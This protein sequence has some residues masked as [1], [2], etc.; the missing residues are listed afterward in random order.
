MPTSVAATVP[1]PVAVRRRRS[2][3]ARTGP[4][5]CA[6][7]SAGSSTAARDGGRTSCSAALGR[8]SPASPSAPRGGRGA[9]WVRHGAAAAPRPGGRGLLPGRA[10]T[11]GWDAGRSRRRAG[12][13]VVDAAG[14]GRLLRRPTSTHA[15]RGRGHPHRRA[16][17]ASPRADR[18]LDGP[19]AQRP[20]PRVPRAHRRLRPARR[21]RSAPAPTTA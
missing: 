14:L 10:A 13:V 17:R 21:R 12:D 19:H 7:P 11:P 15:L 3:P 18:R 5:R 1:V 16:R 2:T 20:G 4:R 6:A 9:C 8:R